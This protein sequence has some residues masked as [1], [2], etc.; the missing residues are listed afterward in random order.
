MEGL[1]YPPT[2]ASCIYFGKGLLGHLPAVQYSSGTW[3]TL[4]GS[5]FSQ[6][7]LTQA[8]SMMPK[9]VPRDTPSK[10]RICLPAS[11]SLLH[12]RIKELCLA[13]L[14]APINRVLF[15]FP[16][17]FVSRR[18]VDPLLRLEHAVLPPIPRVPRA[19]GRTRLGAKERV[20]SAASVAVFIMSMT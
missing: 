12:Y 18:S 7:F 9:P 14:V 17:T 2:L 11:K 6:F 16:V 4:E 19:R 20:P 10:G 15:C 1:V 13:R 8:N 5:S 3:S